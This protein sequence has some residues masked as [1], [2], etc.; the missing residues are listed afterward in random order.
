MVHCLVQ[1][2]SPR[3]MPGM[4]VVYKKPNCK[5]CSTSVILLAYMG[6]FSLSS[7]FCNFLGATS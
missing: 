2:L 5:I 4:K 7:D 3:L 6:N 1:Y